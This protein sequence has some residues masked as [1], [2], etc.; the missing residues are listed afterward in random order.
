MRWIVSVAMV[1]A[2]A[3]G[4]LAQAPEARLRKE[5]GNYYLKKR[6]YEK[7]KDEYLAA[8]QVDPDYPEAHY[9]LGVV[10]FFRLQDY[11]R[12][13]YHFVR[14]A[15]LQ[16]DAS[17]LDQVRQLTLQ[18]LER[19]EQAERE[20]YERALAAGTAEALEAFLR[21]H[22]DSAYRE[23][24]RKKLEVLRKYQ[25][26]KAHWEQEVNAAY[27]RALVEGRPEAL[28]AFLA[29]YPDAPQ[30]GEARRLREAW[31]KEQEAERGAYER[32]QAEGTPE[33]LEAFLAAYPQGRYAIEAQRRL[34]HLRAAEK[35]FRIA[36]EARS[37][38]G[39][40]AFLETYPGTPHEAEARDLLA[41]LR[42]EEE[43]RKAREAEEAAVRA[44]E[45]EARR[46]REAEEAARREREAVLRA[47]ADQAW[48]EAEAADTAEAYEAFRAAYPDH[49]MA[50]EARRRAAV[51]RERAQAAP[52]P[53]AA[54]PAEPAKAVLE[55]DW[56]RAQ[57]ADTAE[58]YRSFLEAHPEGEEAE[59][60]RRRLEELDARVE[61]AEQSLPRE[62]RK[63]LERY[64]KMLQGD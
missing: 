16:P 52:A 55:A 35:A 30:A 51:I 36:K 5:A 13:L 38:P 44:R 4:A 33:A 50:E 45:E 7:A 21:E 40:E 23:D 19:I 43:A 8:L 17:D 42:A 28:D 12:A 58:A 56:K 49:P 11:P 48:A 62:K 41:Q 18:A 14:Y 10:Y 27:Q 15:E 26:E 25:E 47:Q 20:A 57:A 9:N 3:G 59:A 1:L 34:D 24:A 46:A 61:E 39:L 29:R 64:R 2:L 53:P 63:A 22:P 54:A 37:V 31:A 6:E 32:A 60:A